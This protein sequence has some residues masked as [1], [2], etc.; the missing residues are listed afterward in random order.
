MPVFRKG[1]DVAA[2]RAREFAETYADS[3]LAHI[4]VAAPRPATVAWM[5]CWYLAQATADPEALALWEALIEKHGLGERRLTITEDDRSR[6]IDAVSG[7][8]GIDMERARRAVGE[9]RRRYP[10][11]AKFADELERRLESG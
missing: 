8:A 5:L 6:I 2:Y 11:E 1:D 10:Q 7:D 9:F 4:K 3:I